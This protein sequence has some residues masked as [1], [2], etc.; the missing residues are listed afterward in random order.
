MDDLSDFDLD[1]SA[2]RAWSIF[3]QRLADHLAGMPDDQTLL[4]ASQSGLDDD[5]DAGSAPYVLFKARGG[6]ML[7]AEAVS[8]AYLDRTYAL[9]EAGAQRMA[10]LGW[11]PPTY[12]PR[13]EPDSGSA[14]YW[15]DVQRKEGD[16]VAA[17]TTR[18]FREVWSIA[19][20]VFLRVEPVGRTDPAPDLGIAA[21]AV[22]QVADELPEAVTPRDDDHLR[23]LVERVL[24]ER[25]GEEPMKDSDG[26][27]P[28]RSGSALVFVQ[29]PTGLSV[30]TLFAPLVRDISGRTRAAE[31]VADL[32]RR[33]P[34]VKFM[35]VEDQVVALV[36]LA[37]EPFVPRHL[38]TMLEM[39]A[40]VADRL[41]NVL[42]ERLD[43]RLAFPLDV[44]ARRVE[45][46]PAAHG[47]DSWSDELMTL[48]HAD[49]GE[50]GEVTVP[51][52][53]A[54][55][56]GDRRR[57]LRDIKITS[58]QEISWRQSAAEA[59]AAGERAVAV[60][61]AEESASWEST[62]ET[63]RRALR[64]TMDPDPS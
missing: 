27:I 44:E 17:M 38:S 48:L 64:A 15:L 37:A 14:N 30:V 35:L 5:P 45:T 13:E 12:T 59:T 56:G 24:T 9:D 40:K 36:Q 46:V 21:A 28:L 49:V 7:R 61:C 1:R 55:Y 54:L 43:G 18:A 33:W 10:A 62:V 57:L 58:E 19:H 41:D 52:V 42:A 6:T 53:L 22:E 26:D 11:R 63:L 34:L 16:R 8:N 51:E 4:L 39:L 32:N 20:P 3:Q 50:Q 29:V 31:V 2:G 25:F 47:D 23:A 60:A